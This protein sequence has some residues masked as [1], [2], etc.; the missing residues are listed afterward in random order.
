MCLKTLE[1]HSDLNSFIFTVT[2]LK[3]MSATGQSRCEIY[4]LA[5]LADEE[6]RQ[7]GRRFLE[8][9]GL[10]CDD[11]ALDIVVAEAA[12]LPKRLLE[13]CNAIVDGNGTTLH[14]IRLALKLDWAEEAISYW[15]TLLSPNKGKQVRLGLPTGWQPF[16]AVRLFE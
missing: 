16:E 9:S 1:A 5:P 13:L 8:S 11:R 6:S 7:L 12:G 10:S 15:R 14:D 2:D 4:R 3:A